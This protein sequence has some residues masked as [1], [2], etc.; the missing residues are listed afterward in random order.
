MRCRLVAASTLVALSAA[1]CGGSALD[2]ADDPVLFGE[3][4]RPPAIPADFP[5]PPDAVIGSTMIDRTN[6]RTEMALQVGADLESVVRYFNIGL[7]SQ[8]FVV[9]ASSGTDTSWTISFGRDEL[10]GE[11]GFTAQ[12]DITRV[13]VEVNDI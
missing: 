9:G 7:V 4:V 5:I 12:G 10:S 2:V 3:G 11:I 13:L 8:G 1:G 6:H